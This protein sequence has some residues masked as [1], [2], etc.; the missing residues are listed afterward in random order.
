MKFASAILCRLAL[1]AVAL[2]ATASPASAVTMHYTLTGTITGSLD[3]TPLVATPFTIEMETPIISPWLGGPST[4]AITFVSVSDPPSYT[5][6]TLDGIGTGLF[7]QN[8]E[9][10]LSQGQPPGLPTTLWFSGTSLNFPAAAYLYSYDLVGQDLRSAFSAANPLGGC[11]GGNMA[12]STT[13][14]S[15]QFDQC[16]GQIL[17]FSST[18]VPVPAMGWLLGATVLSL[19]GL[20]RRQRR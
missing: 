20:R 14:G 19:T 18:V 13:L 12:L 9:I 10:F 3:S 15:L 2:A 6:I 8:T 1:L 7:T 4:Y 16:G 5:S 17:T 11:F